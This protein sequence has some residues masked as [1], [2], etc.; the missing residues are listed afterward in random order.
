[1]STDSKNAP[2]V[3]LVVE[4]EVLSHMVL[5]DMLA[6]EG[7]CVIDARNSRDALALLEARSD[8]QV[9]LTGRRTP[10]EID[11]L[12]LARIVN[13]RWPEIRIIVTSGSR[14]SAHE[15]PPGA[16]FLPKPYSHQ[17][18]LGVLASLLPE[19]VSAAPLL[20]QGLPPSTGAG[21]AIQ[22]AAAAAEPDKT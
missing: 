11:G 4:S 18:L 1:M 14:L 22:I 7:Y 13:K 20:P 19:K 12:T 17:I 6:D 10:G 2:P 16:R 5:T 8:V 21:E 15:L 9:V 3:I